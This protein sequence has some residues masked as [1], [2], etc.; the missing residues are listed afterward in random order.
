ML[1]VGSVCCRY[2]RPRAATIIALTDGMLWAIDRFVFVNSLMRT[3]ALRKE[4]L[5]TLRRVKAFH[6][7]TISQLQR[8]VDLMREGS[9]V[10]GEAII[11]Q[12][13]EGK[14]FYIIVEGSCRLN[15]VDENG[16]DEDVVILNEND[17]FGD[18]ALLSSEPSR[19]TATSMTY[20][21]VLVVSDHPISRLT[22]SHSSLTSSPCFR[23]RKLDLKRCWGA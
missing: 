23:L 8:L 10:E 22:N 17:Y 4:I 9:Y 6:A 12:G 16:Q 19:F 5:Q 13:E 3:Q 1:V 14:Q 20:V 2:G 11:K 15:R 18:T 21:E 7:L